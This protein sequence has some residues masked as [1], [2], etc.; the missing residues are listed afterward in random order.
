[1][2]GRK[3]PQSAA[4]SERDELSDAVMAHMAVV[5]FAPDGEVLDANDV[6]CRLMGYEKAEIVGQN[7]KMLV[8]SDTTHSPEYRK[9]WDRL[10]NGEDISE[11]VPRIAK[12]GHLVWLQASYVPMTSGSGAVTRIV[13]FATDVTE[14]VR[15]AAREK[16]KL[17]AISR[18]Q[19]IIEF[20][21]EGHV[22]DANENFLA[23]TGYTLDEIRGKHHA[24]FVPDDIASK[25]SYRDFWTTLARGEPKAGA[26]RRKRKQGTE[27]WLQA[28]YNPIIGARGVPV[29]VIK[30]AHDITQIKNRAIDHAGQIEALGRSQAVIE[31]EPNGTILTANENFL[32]AMG[33]EAHEIIGKHHRMFVD[34]TEAQSSDYAAFWEGLKSGAHRSDEFRRIGKG[35]RDVWIQATYNP[36]T[37]D[38]GRVIKVVKFATDIT[39]RKLAVGAIAAAITRLANNDLSGR[40]DAP[41]PHEFEGLKVGFN[42]AIASLSQVVAGITDRSGMILSEV[43][44]IAGAAQDLSARTEKQ[45]AALE[46]T[47]ASL[48][49]MASSVDHAAESAD[50]ATRTADETDES[51][52]I[53]L[54][55]AKR[56]AAAMTEIAESSEKVRQITN[57]I[58]D[59][60][61]Q[62]NLLALNA[63]VEA[64]RAG[65]TGRGFAVVAAEVRQL[66]QRSSDSSREIADLINATSTQVQGG[67]T[68]VEDSREALV[69]IADSVAHIRMQVQ[70]LAQSA[71]E[72]SQGLKEI[73]AA[74]NQLDQTT[75]QNVA[76]FEETTAA[77]QSLKS[78]TEQ[79][80]ASTRAFTFN[81]PDPTPKQTIAPAERQ[82]A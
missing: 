56:A 75:Q 27:I 26:F 52:R 1:M 18:S 14:A 45:A 46:E 47:A 2:I 67:V 53:G 25:P 77:T 78:V 4:R 15:N 44:Q 74:A 35:G 73:N 58:D 62:T 12:E 31:F 39:A 72:Q 70:G 69:Q 55:K 40:I 17:A 71:K 43:A 22:L 30:F 81:A 50:A 37:D 11:R 21:L 61:F 20:D 23:A 24:I 7:H 80:S 13:K 3:K 65:E 33:Y 79:L 38:D 54:E 6:F 66:A 36:I 82:R 10:R 42:S 19:A 57:V 76:M 41:M 63:G 59:I 28:T 5:W 32:S 48:D 8:G 51:T 9:F 34:P 49:Q 68:L 16:S 64:A 29:G 60:A